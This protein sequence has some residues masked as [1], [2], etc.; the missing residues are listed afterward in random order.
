MGFEFFKK[1]SKENKHLDDTEKPWEQVEKQLR[2]YIANPRELPIAELDNLRLS[3]VDNL[4]PEEV[5]EIVNKL[6]EYYAP[7]WKSADWHSL[8]RSEEFP[9]PRSLEEALVL[10]RK[11][12]PELQKLFMRYVDN[13]LLFEKLVAKEKEADQRNPQKTF[14]RL[15]PHSKDFYR[16]KGINIDNPTIEDVKKYQE[17]VEYTLP[18]VGHEL[19]RRTDRDLPDYSDQERSDMNY[20]LWDINDLWS[21]FDEKGHLIKRLR[22]EMWAQKLQELKTA[23]SG[24]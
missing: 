3:E 10:L 18:L 16:G 22:G 14:V 8:P 20:L 15:D 17:R 23:F 6:S 1:Q 21:E 19:D 12:R 24:R 13:E 9:K 7:F 5:D 2:E 4:T 11:L